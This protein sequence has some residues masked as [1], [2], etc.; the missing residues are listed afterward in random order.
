MTFQPTGTFTGLVSGTYDLVVQD[1]NGCTTSQPVTLNDE[2]G[3][4]IDNIDTTEPLCAGDADGSIV[5]VASGGTAPL[6]YSADNGVT[7]QSTSTFTGL[8]AGTYDI[9]VQDANGCTTAQQVIINEPGALDITLTTTD[10]DCPGNDGSATAIVTGGTVAAD[11]TYQWDAATGDQITQTATGLTAGTYSVTVTDDNGCTITGTATVI[12]NCGCNVSLD[13]VQT[14]ANCNNDTNGTAI[15]TLVGGTD[16]VTYQWDATTG[17]QTTQTATGLGAG[18]YSVTVTDINTCEAIGTV[19][20]AEPDAMTASTSTTDELCAAS[21]GTATVTV[22]G[23]TVAA[24]Y[25]YLWDDAAMQN[26]QTATGLTAGTY[27]VTVTDDNGCTVTASAAVNELAGPVIDNINSTNPTCGNADGSIDITASGGTDPLEYSIDNGLTFQPAGTFTGLAAGT[28]DLVVQDVNGCVTTDQISISDE[29][30]PVIDNITTTDA[31]CGS[32]DGGIDIIASGGTAP[33]EY[34]IDNGITFQPTG[35]FSGLAAGTYDIVVQ[36]ANACTTSQQVTIN[37]LAG[38]VIDNIDTTE[39][40]CA[41]GIDGTITITASGGN[42]PLEYSIDNGLTFQADGVFTGIAA[43]TYDVVVQ[44]AVGCSTSAAFTIGEPTMMVAST[45]STDELCSAADGTAT[46]TTM[47]G[48]VA[49]DYTYLWDDAAMQNT[50]TAVGLSAGTYNVTITD[51]NGCTVTAS[52]TVN[53]QA[54]PL[55]DNITSANPTCGNADGSIDITASG[56]A[57][58][59]E[60]S[61]DNGLTF[62]PTGT[63]TGL[64]SGTYDI[65]VQDANACTA[66][67]QVILNDEAGPVID[68]AATVDATCGS[69]DGSITITASG[70]TMPLEYSIDNGVSFQPSGTFIGLAT[71]TYDVVIQDANGCTTAQQVTVN[72]LAGPVIDNIDTTEPL[73]TGGIDGSITIVAS[74]GNAPLEYSI[75]NGLTFQTDGV[76]T[77]IAAG[78]YD[79]VVQDAVGCS[80]SAA[81]TIGEPTMMVAST[82]S[83]DELCSAADGTVTV[84]TT[85]GTVAVDYTYLWDDAA[86][87]NTQTATGLAAGTYNVTVTDDNGCTVTANVIVN[88]QASPVIDDITSANPTCGNADG[89]ID[90]TASGGTAPLEYSIDNGLTFQPAGTFTGLAS[91]TYDI[92]VQDANACTAIDQVILNDEAGPV[93][94]NVATVD[95]TCGSTD[96]SI[97]ITASG[98]T[99]PLEYSIDNGVSFQPSGAFAGLSAGT[100]DIVIQDANGCT[101]AQQVTISDQAAPAID[102]IA[103]TEPTCGNANGIVTITSTGGTAPVEYSIDNGVTFEPTG[104]F[105]DLAAGTYDIVIQDVNGCTVTDQIVLTDQAGATIVDVI[106]ADATCGNSDG[107]ISITTTG[108][109][110]P[111]EYSIDNGVTFEPAGSFIN[112]PAGTYDI[113]V[114]DANNCLATDQAIINDLAGPV[115]DDIP[116]A[117]STCGSSDGSI[118]INAS[119]GTAPLE[120]SIDGGITFQTTNTFSGLVSGTYDIVVQDVNGCTATDQVTLSDESGPA[121]D[122]VVTTDATCGGSDGSITITASGGTAPLEYSIDNGLTFQSDGV[123]TGIAGG[124]YDVVVQDANGCIITQQVTVNDQSAPAIDNVAST[125]PT[126]GDPN[127]T[128]TIT[129]IG[130][131]A[132]IEYSIDNGL[133]FQ[134]NDNFTGLAAG[135][136]DIVVQDVNGCT[137]TDQVILTDQ[138][139][140]VIDNITSTDP[141]CGDSNGAITIASTGGTAPVE[142]SIDNGVTFQAT[143]TF[144][145][146]TQGIYDIVVQD[147]NGCTATDQ[148]VLTDQGGATI[149][150]VATTEPTCG[151]STGTITITASGGTAPLEYSI[152]NG[153]TFQAGDGFT[154]LAAGTYDIIV[155]DANGCTTST[156]AVLTDQGG[157]T[158]DNVASTEPTCG[159]PNGTISITASGGTAPLEYSIDNGATFQPGNGFT[160][161]AAGTYDI[162]VQDANGC[163]TTEQITLT[164][165]AGPTV[166]NIDT[167]DPACNGDTNGSITINA[168]GGT[169]PLQYSIDNGATFQ[170]GNVFSNLG[171][172]TYNIVVTDANGCTTT[173][174]ATLT[175]PAPLTATLS[176]TDASCAGICDGTGTVSPAGGT[177]PYTYLWNNGETTQ[178]AT[179]LCAGTNTV[180]ITDAN[181]CTI[182]ESITTNEPPLLLVTAIPVQDVLCFGDNNGIANATAIGGT[183]PYNYTWDNSALNTGTPTDLPAGANIVTV[184]DANGCTATASVTIGSPTELVAT[185]TSTNVDCFGNSTGT[186]SATASGGTAP[187]SFDWGAID[188]NNVPAGT[189]TVTVIDNNGCITTATTTVTEPPLLTGTL[190]GQDVSCFG[191]SDGT[192]A[193]TMSGGTPPYSYLW[194]NGEVTNPAVL[195]NAGIHTVVATDANGCTFTESINIEQPTPLVPTG[196]GSTP[197]TCFGGNDGTATVSASGGTPPYSYTWNDGQTTQTATGL[198]AGVYTVIITD[199]N[200]CSLPAINV[201][202]TQPDT[203]ITATSSSTAVT[204]NGG[205]DGSATVEAMGGI[206]SYSYTWSNG[207]TGQ[208]IFDLTAGTYAVTITDANNCAYVENVLVSEPDA[209]V[210]TIV[211]TGVSCYGDENGSILVENVTGNNPPYIYS[212]DGE[213]YQA[214]DFF[215]GL[216]GGSY[217]VFVQDIN[218]CTTSETVIV[219]E[220]FELIVDLGADITI[221]LGDSTELFAQVNTTDSLTYTWI[222]TTGLS[223]TDCPNPTVNITETVTYQVQITNA[224]GCTATDNIMI[225]VDKNRNIYIPNVFSPDNDGTNDVFMIYG[226]KGVE[227][228]N[229]FR[230][231]DRWGEMVWEAENFQTD[232]PSFGW[233][234]TFRGQ[235]LNPAVFVYYAEVTFIDGV[236]LL[237]KGDVTLMK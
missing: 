82:S 2:A 197:V 169:T 139:G 210:L 190:S 98:G 154:G 55:I 66:I 3:P 97:T 159:D 130:G 45:S 167:V 111:V 194:D 40:L 147:A 155:Q 224:N 110:A 132:P 113:V 79:V 71:G 9:V 217:E 175:E 35:T 149:D 226:G 37:D 26:T 131:T 67:D 198:T 105:T 78:T 11:Y 176:G 136:Y 10:E 24:D 138:A 13:L 17:S 46:V 174:Q 107:T 222:P 185:A 146:L 116:T 145:G 65:V 141:T 157:A 7:L 161:L 58:P 112:L 102:N 180:V 53:D 153:T 171:D 208:S 163:L 158:I 39:P 214:G 23:G 229:V 209:Y 49:V 88:D 59:L 91:G 47:G 196:A 173:D 183:A 182:T 218:G 215:G 27:N 114:Q 6:E 100:Y 54:S 156:Q 38:P 225:T 75:D 204:C 142:Y 202:V 191:G 184:T 228:V 200:G 99:I 126:C 203:P 168:T 192:A 140:P 206:P 62:Q 32:A 236:T 16:P 69:A 144:A 170:A 233:D 89:S 137:A 90:I 148:V 205:N 87:Q 230:I 76:F 181:G 201:T 124:I 109:T 36:D 151:N 95:A 188:V 57:A 211:P 123:F 234:G 108:G 21:D 72:D 199:A 213:N 118:I 122:N 96:G 212:L 8:L 177:A 160:G 94:D 25:T 22:A 43:G 5:I 189:Y 15:A 135:T 172:G 193:A 121:I 101:T 84:T 237:Y 103:S 207:Q 19:T 80:T 93:I 164:D 85:G 70:G 178:T 73:C 4:I 166:D 221:E 56:G 117:N 29:A 115:I 134:T 227:G 63:F 14:D 127:G 223:C 42:A 30:G 74:G 104:A 165:Q 28:Y 44:D 51:D 120:Y 231:Y 232:D 64:A 152:D 41:G 106:I 216:A 61:I 68:N 219:D 125:E 150:N 77:G 34:S 220:P 86:M 12:N 143:G 33:L 31:T 1:A 186:V 133:T 92:V 48:T 83:T 20:I 50:Q 129:S 81:F 52:A 195:L 119:G 162:V 179:M 235:K 187:Y 18:T 60:Y 128:I